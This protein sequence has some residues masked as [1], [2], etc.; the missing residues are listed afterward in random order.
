MCIY[1]HPSIILIVSLV[2][3][4][5]IVNLYA[6]ENISFLSADTDYDITIELTQGTISNIRKVRVTGIADIRNSSFLMLKPQGV[7]GDG[8]F[9]V[10]LDSVK[11]IVPSDRA[12]NLNLNVTKY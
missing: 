3:L 11:I 9:F 7:A 6:A 2:A 10:V 4:A 1:A 8:D 5:G 12:R